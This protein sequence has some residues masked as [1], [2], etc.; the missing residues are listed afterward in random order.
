MPFDSGIMFSIIPIFIVIITILI[1][2]TIL[3]GIVRGIRTWSY[4]NSQPILTV[5]A[6]VVAKRNHVTSH[7]NHGTDNGMHHHSTHTTYYMTFEVESG[8][9]LEF[10]VDQ[11]EYGLLVEGDIGKLTFQGTRYLGF[12][13]QRR[14]ERE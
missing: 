14:T 5:V 3:V 8:D 9:R 6:R 1:F 7:M 12:E 2:G 10:A 13:R 4:N 11:K